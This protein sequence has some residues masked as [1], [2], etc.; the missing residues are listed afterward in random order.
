VSSSDQRGA[1]GGSRHP[2]GPAALEEFLRGTQLFKG[3]DAAVV[4]K[5]SAHAE[6]LEFVRGAVILR[7]GAASDGLVILLRGRASHAVVSASSGAAT[8]LDALQPGD[9]AGDVAVILRASQP[10]SLLADEPCVAVRLRGEIVDTLIAKVPQFLHNLARRL[11]TRNVGLSMTSMRGGGASTPAR[12]MMIAAEAMTRFVEVSDYEPAAKVVQLVPS[13]LILAHRLLPLRLEGNALTVGMVSPRN[14]TALSELRQVVPSLE[15]E[16]A[17]ISQDDFT[18]AVQRLRIDGGGRGEAAR[19]VRVIDPDTLQF[20]VV[21]QERDADKVVKVVG[22]EVV[23]AVSR[24]IAGALQREASDVHVEP[25][26][27]GV[28]VRYRVQGMLVDAPDVIPPSFAKGVVA[29]IKIL[30][31]LDITDRRTPQDGRIGMT[32]GN[33]E[34]D[35][36]VSTLPSSRGEKVVLRVLE[37]AGVSRPL[38]HI[39]LE[40]NLLAAARRAVLR[41]HGA[42]LVAGATG[43]GKSSSLYGMLQ[44]RR[45]A[46]PDSSVLMVEDPI[47]YRL[48]GVTQVQVNAGIGLGFAQVLRA[49]L[50]QDPDVIVVGETRD[51]ETARLALESAMTGHLLFTSLHANDVMATLQ[52]LETLGCSRT[53]VAQSLALVVVQRLV[54]RLCAQCARV[55]APAPALLDALVARRLAER[56][57]SV[58]LPRAV[59]CDACNGTGYAGRVA[60]TEGLALNE[61]LRAALMTGDGFAELA[62]A[63]AQARALH[64]FAQCASFLMARKVIA[65]TEA[66]LAVA[67]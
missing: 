14:A 43:S 57:A 41:P 33:R 16:V 27:G 62:K 50:R 39:F 10:Y 60:V 11:A 25:E 21:D 53:L 56:G 52:R 66:L 35:L 18:L 58:T 5:V 45:R 20:D 23:R 65:A 22:D 61:E 3:C 36:R 59:G 48:A 31:G 67:E 6:V 24:L 17:A 30:A 1:A 54:R 12:T 7:A 29:R 46:R 49:A 32:A 9:H 15:L 28:R 19:G 63:A 42:V 13:K 51:P 26:V 8:V 44:E 47:E 38:E 4:S 55:E 64:T 34:V 40:P 37:G 2:N